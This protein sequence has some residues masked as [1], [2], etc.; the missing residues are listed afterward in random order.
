[1]LTGSDEH[2]IELSCN[3]LIEVLDDWVK[4][5]NIPRLGYYGVTEDDLDKIIEKSSNKNNQIELTT[6]EMK[7]ILKNRL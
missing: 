2:D 7:V 6:D 4:T 5:L 1:L 3:H